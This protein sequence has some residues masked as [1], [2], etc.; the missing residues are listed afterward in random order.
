[1][2]AANM[3]QKK[4]SI[5]SPACLQRILRAMVQHL[6]LALPEELLLLCCLLLPA[7]R[8][9]TDRHCSITRHLPE[10]INK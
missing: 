5:A 3:R 7:D 4:K 10:I 1:M 9:S 2:S 8:A 6:C